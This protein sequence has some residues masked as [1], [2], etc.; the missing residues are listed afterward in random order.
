MSSQ[1]RFQ[2]TRA[3]I[4]KALRTLGEREPAVARAVAQVGLP[5]ERRRA[6]GF[7]ALARIIIGQQVSTKA[8]SAIAGRV[9]IA[10]GGELSPERVDAAADTDLRG[11][12]LSGQKLGYLRALTESVTTGAL[13][14]E[15]LPAMADDDV[16]TRITAIKWF[17]DWSAQM[18]LMFSLG[19]TDVWPVGDLA[20]R[21]GFGRIM[22]MP[23]R[24]TP[25]QTAKAA[26]HLQP[27]RSALALLCW[28]FYS[29]APL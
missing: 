19:R 5:D 29:E 4:A 18:Y 13:P 24:P 27:Y 14:I 9:V 26:A 7:D 20:V 1:P 28:K 15:E 22:A 21:A 3:H 12:G 8:A 16:I 6:H 10:L 17:G 11:A 23:E 2:L 25:Q